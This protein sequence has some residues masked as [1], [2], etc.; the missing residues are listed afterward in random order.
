MKKFIQYLGWTTLLL[1]VILYGYS[2]FLLNFDFNPSVTLFIGFMKGPI[3]YVDNLLNYGAN[4][5][6]QTIVRVILALL[7]FIFSI[8]VVVKNLLIK[9]VFRAIV[10]ILVSFSFTYFSIG[11]FV[12]TFSLTNDDDNFIRAVSYGLSLFENGSF[13]ELLLTVGILFLLTGSLFLLSFAELL[14]DG[15]KINNYSAGQKSNKKTSIPVAPQLIHSDQEAQDTSL[16]E[17]VKLVLAEEIQAM[18]DPSISPHYNQNSN[19]YGYPFDPN[20]MRRIVSEE[21][22]RSQ[23][24][25]ITRTEAQTLLAQ[26]VS[27]LK[28]KLKIK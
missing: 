25:Y 18:K 20:L 2:L 6:V 14:S 1:A 5:P 11:L 17:L 22:A 28:A 21:L 27:D 23:N 15:T 4:I 7:G 10:F 9:K 26:E 24:L 12:G 13:E 16:T 19:Q 8:V 3:L